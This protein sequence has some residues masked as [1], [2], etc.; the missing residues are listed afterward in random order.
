MIASLWILLASLGSP[1]T[2]A[3]DVGQDER[4]FERPT[5]GGSGAEVERPEILLRTPDELPRAEPGRWGALSDPERRDEALQGL[6][7]EVVRALMRAER[8]YLEDRFPETLEILY[9]L[10]TDA[11]D[12]PPALMIL[13][14]AYFRLR[15]Y[16]DCR[17]ALERFLEVLP[18]DLW[19]TQALGHS[20]Y[21]LGDFARAREHYEAVID[22]IP[23]EMGESPEAVRGLALC[24]MRQG[25]A[26]RA[27]ELLDHVIELRPDHAEAFT[28]KARIL[29]D[30]DRLEEALEAANRSREI[31]PY[32]PQAWYFA[33]RILYDLGREDEAVA[34]EQRWRELDRIAQEVRALRMQLRFRP[35]SFPIVYRLCELAAELGD[36]DTVRERLA[37]L[38]LARPEEMP[39]VQV[40]IFVLDT[41][42][43][44]GDA[45][46]AR[47]AAL[48]LEETCKDR[49]EAWRRL[50][51]Y[52]ASVRDRIN[53]VRCA[54]EAARFAPRDDGSPST[55]T[56]GG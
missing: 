28:F 4:T 56:S 48:A 55:G 30:E 46:G 33:M 10:L 52:Y 19:R 50:E 47:V 16:A 25:D 27:L 36:V 39:E 51:S 3:Q 8:A 34:T 7:P 6:D 15:R 38:V 22:A 32:E 13:G 42:V 29:F 17:V 31:D 45:E 2:P 21:S 14:T 26:D 24:H 49:V 43:S 18:A 23:E 5:P 53:Q 9:P 12:F 35:G 41:L 11:P 44:L 1:G 54:S 20:Y 40:R 37:D